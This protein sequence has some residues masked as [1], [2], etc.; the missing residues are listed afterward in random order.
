MV[1]EI[2]VHHQIPLPEL[3][4]ADASLTVALIA[5]DHWYKENEPQLATFFPGRTWQLLRKG[6]EDRL[7]GDFQET[8]AA[9]RHSSDSDL[10]MDT[11]TESDHMSTDGD[12]DNRP[13]RSSQH[14]TGH[15]LQSTSCAPQ[16]T[17]NETHIASILSAQM[18]SFS[19]SM[20]RELTAIMTHAQTKTGDEI[21][22][23]V[24]QESS[25]LHKTIEEKTS[26]LRLSNDTLGNKMTTLERRLNVVE[27]TMAKEMRSNEKKHKGGD[28][29]EQSEEGGVQVS[30]DQLQKKIEDLKSAQSAMEEKIAENV[31]T[32]LNNTAVTVRSAKPST[33]QPNDTESADGIQA[34]GSWANGPPAA[35]PV[36]NSANTTPANPTSTALADSVARASSKIPLRH[37]GDTVQVEA[38]LSAFIAPSY[39]R[40]R[41]SVTPI[42]IPDSQVPVPHAAFRSEHQHDCRIVHLLGGVD[43]TTR[44]LKNNLARLGFS[45]RHIFIGSRIGRDLIEMIVRVSYYPRFRALCELYSNFLTIVE[46]LDPVN[47]P[48]KLKNRT[49]DHGV[50][51]KRCHDRF[52]KSI[53]ST[54][55][56]IK[57]FYGSFLEELQER[58]VARLDHQDESA[59]EEYELDMPCEPSTS[60]NPPL[61]TAL[62][63]ELATCQPM[64]EDPD[65]SAITGEKRSS[66]EED[67]DVNMD[68][69]RF[70]TVNSPLERATQNCR[71]PQRQEKAQKTAADDTPS[72]TLDAQ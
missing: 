14:H 51:W 65:H 36:S 18:A 59:N 24:Q 44:D 41:A 29:R 54:N 7:P 31:L 45:L 42:T 38:A 6:L 15:T 39:N 47:G 67:E 37:K 16:P 21:M 57:D 66:Q 52:R 55:G 17:A 62:P 9:N 71:L 48:A 35:S 68:D 5:A 32:R 25:R 11:E 49:E 50:S 1:V 69:L 61:D 40:K 34:L 8:L 4:P 53:E 26:S 12:D 30:L 63:P 43:Q 3:P 72:K 22:K 33:S 64:D 23:K 46:H 2:L 10:G 70:R 13:D 58:H 19:E 27:A 28:N 20:L 60:A 56:F